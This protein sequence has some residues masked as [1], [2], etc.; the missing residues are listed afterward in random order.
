MTL[1]VLPLSADV[2]V[3]VVVVVGNE[4]GSRVSFALGAT[5]D[6]RR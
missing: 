5:I 3:V 6:D 4:D 2:V 1:S